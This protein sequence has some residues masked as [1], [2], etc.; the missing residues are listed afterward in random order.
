MRFSFYF[1][2]CW[3]VYSPL[4]LLLITCEG[5]RCYIMPR[6]SS[7]SATFLSLTWPSEQ[8][9]V[10]QVDETLL[11]DEAWGGTRPWYRGY[12]FH[13]LVHTAPRNRR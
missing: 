12:S 10:E 11:L 8:H 6:P 3:R 13:A 4:M 9:Q 7:F 1:R 5:R 2:S